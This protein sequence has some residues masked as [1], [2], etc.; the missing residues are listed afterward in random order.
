MSGRFR[1]ELLSVHSKAVVRELAER[2]EK[3]RMSRRMF[4]TKEEAVVLIQ[5]AFRARRARHLE[6]A[7]KVIMVSHGALVTKER[8]SKMG[9]YKEGSGNR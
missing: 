5:R 1:A 6:K 8:S 4:A 3:K 2:L 7:A 9:L